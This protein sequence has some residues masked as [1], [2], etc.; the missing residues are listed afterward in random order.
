MA[1]RYEVAHR[2]PDQ[3]SR[4][5]WF[6]RWVELMTVLDPGWGAAVQRYVDDVLRRSPA[7]D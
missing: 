4:R 2:G 7:W 5:I 1:T 6:A 3:D